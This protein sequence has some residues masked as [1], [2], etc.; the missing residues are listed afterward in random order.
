MLFLCLN[1][2][3]IVYFLQYRMIRKDDYMLLS[4]DQTQALRRSKGE[5]NATTTGLAREI[6]VSRYAL[7]N[8][9]NGN[10]IRRT[11]GEKI[12]AYLIKQLLKSQPVE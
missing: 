6:G 8:A 10:A 11:T 2:S 1:D 9:L 4:T 3:L 7:A 12:N 5:R